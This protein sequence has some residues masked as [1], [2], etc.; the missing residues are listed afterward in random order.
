[1]QFNTRKMNNPI[2]NW[3]EGLNGKKIYRWLINTGK[4]VQHHSLLEKHK[5]K[6]Q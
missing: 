6:P 2:K 1:M 5:S 4:D 3:A